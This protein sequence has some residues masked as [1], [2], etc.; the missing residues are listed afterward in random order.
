MSVGAPVIISAALTGVAA[1]RKQCPAI[2]YTPAEIAAEAISAAQAGAAFSLFDPLILK[3]TLFGWIFRSED[4]IP[5]IFPVSPKWRLVLFGLGAMQFARHP[6][7]LIEF[8]KRRFTSK[9]NNRLRAA[10]EATEGAHP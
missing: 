1:N 6:E 10:D 7:G 3:G 8:G 4:R 9:L 5:G 2:P